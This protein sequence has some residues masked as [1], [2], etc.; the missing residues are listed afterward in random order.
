MGTDVVIKVIAERVA[1]VLAGSDPSI[2]IYG[3][4][5]M[6]DLRDG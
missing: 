3:S 2:Y 1:G 6:G 4:C 5:A